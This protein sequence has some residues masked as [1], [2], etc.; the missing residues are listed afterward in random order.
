MDH[1]TFS[2]TDQQGLLTSRLDGVG[3]ATTF[4]YIDLNSDGV[5]DA[6]SEMVEP[7]GRT[8]TFAY[9]NGRL[10]TRTDFAGRVTA[11]TYDA[12]GTLRSRVEPSSATQQ[13]GAALANISA[14]QGTQSNRA[15]RYTARF[16]HLTK[17]LDR[18]LVD[19]RN[20]GESQPAKGESSVTDRN[21]KKRRAQRTPALRPSF[22]CVSNTAFIYDDGSRGA[23]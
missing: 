11:M 21:A 8:T 12:A 6:L 23:I 20:P 9:S 18:S 2:L 13:F 22:L 5:P 14:G 16:G 17:T 19:I 15:T 10:E 3:N 1:G 4:S 7:G